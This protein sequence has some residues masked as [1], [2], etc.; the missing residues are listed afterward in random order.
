MFRIGEDQQMLPLIGQK[1]QRILSTDSAQVGLRNLKG[2]QE[3]QPRSKL[4]RRQCPSL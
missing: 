3:S 4:G 2:D 1:E